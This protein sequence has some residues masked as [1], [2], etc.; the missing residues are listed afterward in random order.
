MRKVLESSEFTRRVHTG[1]DRVVLL[2]D[3]DDLG[4]HATMLS[5][6]CV[7]SATVVFDGSSGCELH[8]L[9]SIVL[10]LRERA[11]YHK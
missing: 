9:L 7:G 2:V 1:I 5:G 6:E 4:L 10:I 3:T 11:Q 8:F